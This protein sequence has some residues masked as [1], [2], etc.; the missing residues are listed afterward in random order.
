MILLTSIEYMKLFLILLVFLIQNATFSQEIDTSF[1]NANWELVQSQDSASFYRVQE[2]LNDSVTKIRDFYLSTKTLYCTGEVSDGI[3]SGR[4][5][6]Y[7]EN[8]EVFK[9]YKYIN[10]GRNKHWYKFDENALKPNDHGIYMTTNVTPGYVGGIN[11]F[12]DFISENFELPKKAKKKNIRSFKV[13][14]QLIINEEG[15]IIDIWDQKKGVMILNEDFNSE[16]VSD[17]A[18]TRTKKAINR[19][20]KK[21]LSKN[22]VWTPATVKDKPVKS[23]KYVSITF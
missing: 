13:N 16:D 12:Y 18:L 9:D 21:F 10:H 19:K 20:M 3:N 14:Y 11:C 4:W 2:P 5:T 8:G 22:T 6:F 7:D 15:K 1:Y 17:K 23:T